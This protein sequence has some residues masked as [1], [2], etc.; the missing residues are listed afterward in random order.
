M[1]PCRTRS[2]VTAATRSA[3]MRR[4]PTRLRDT[5]PA[6]Q[7]ER[8]ADAMTHSLQLRGE[9][10]GSSAHRHPV[11][12]HATYHPRRVTAPSHDPQHSR[13]APSNPASLLVISWGVLGVVGILSSAIV[14]LLPMAVEP[15]RDGSLG[16][17]HVIAY[18]G[19][20]AFMAYSEGYR[21]FHQQFSP[22]VV[23][24]AL[25]L[26]STHNALF[27][28]FAPVF[29]MSLFHATKKR[30]IVAW[31]I[32]LMVTTLVVIVRSVSQPWRGIIDAGVVVGLGIGTVSILWYFVAALRGI[33]PP[34]SPDLPTSRA[35]SLSP[36]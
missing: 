9:F 35:E 3:A 29:C 23:A 32:L 11:G 33:T 30:K 17:M 20:V 4:Q 22:R 1:V 26:P 18:L 21:G 13:A 36:S 6:G 24:R 10:H 31:A 2:V 16:A 34:V 25:A 12:D 14:R 28:A 27:V 8:G 7:H 15:L 5:K 19:S